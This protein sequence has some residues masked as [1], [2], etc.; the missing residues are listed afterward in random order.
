[1][2]A[3]AVVQVHVEERVV[4]GRSAAAAAAT[5]RHR[6][7]AAV[8]VV[9]RPVMD[10]VVTVVAAAAAAAVVRVRP[11]VVLAVLLLQVYGRGHAVTV[12]VRVA[13]AVRRRDDDG[14]LGRM[15]IVMVMMMMVITAA[16]G[17]LLQLIVR[18]RPVATVIRSV[19]GR[20]RRVLFGVIQT[21]LGRVSSRFQRRPSAT[22]TTAQALRQIVI[23][24]Q[25]AADAVK[26]VH[27]GRRVTGVRR[28]HHVGRPADAADAAT[29]AADHAAAARVVV[30]SHVIR[31]RTSHV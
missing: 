19:I 21:A 6:F 17:R 29:A 12:Q 4:H 15:V 8:V 30:H 22:A 28:G 26:V 2:V 9:R 16:V 18:R 20:R 14:R 3:A 11:A 23:G 13:Q 7:A 24:H 27:R 25:P 1:M 31:L 5:I 10:A